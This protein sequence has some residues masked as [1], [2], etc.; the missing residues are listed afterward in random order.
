MTSVGEQKRL[1]T[2]FIKLQQSLGHAINVLTAETTNQT[3][4]WE[5]MCEQ[6]LAIFQLHASMIEEMERITISDDAFSTALKNAK[7]I[8]AYV[9]VQ[10]P[11]VLFAKAF[12]E[13]YLSRLQAKA[14]AEA[15]AL[16]EETERIQAEEKAKQEAEA[17]AANN[18]VKEEM[19]E[20]GN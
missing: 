13:A 18:E 12:Y 4:G 17:E 2:Q 16:Q 19:T 11:R 1:I 15:K 14:E 3:N 9:M 7:E 8:Q 20:S 10:Q 5:R 6:T